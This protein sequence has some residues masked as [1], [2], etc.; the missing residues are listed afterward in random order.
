MPDER[1]DLVDAA[2]EL[3]VAYHTAH[4]WALTGKLTA[5]VTPKRPVL[6]VESVKVA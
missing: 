2:K 1:I 6:K 5:E 3:A 4:R